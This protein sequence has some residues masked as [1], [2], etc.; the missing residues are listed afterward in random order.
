MRSRYTAF[1][2]G[3]EHYIRATWHPDTCPASIV[4][5]P[6][7]QWIGLRIVRTE[8]GQPG[9]ATGVVEYVAKSKRNGRAHRLHETSR[10]ECIEHRWLYVD[11]KVHPR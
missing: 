8:R 2:L 4:L 1:A 6:E 9:E 10:F 3:N 7:Q 5:M 11:G